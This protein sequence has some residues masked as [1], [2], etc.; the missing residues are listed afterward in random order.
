MVEE[1]TR[2]S[3]KQTR[4][5]QIAVSAI[6]MR[7]Q[8]GDVIVTEAG[9]LG[10]HDWR[11]L[12]GGGASK[13][14]LMGKEGPVMLQDHVVFSSLILALELECLIQCRA[15]PYP[16]SVPLQCIGYVRTSQGM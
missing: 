7:K 10:S 9:G 11:R 3:R 4:A 2:T 8:Q 5:F 13:L 12:L 14:K 16:V 1:D 6:E 15:V